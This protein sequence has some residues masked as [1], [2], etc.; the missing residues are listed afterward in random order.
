MISIT[1]R[2]LL[3]VATLTNAR[4]SAS[5]NFYVHGSDLESYKL[6]FFRFGAKLWNE[7]T[8]HIRHLSKNK[9]KKTLRKLLFD[10]L[11]SEYDYINTPTLIKKVKL[12]KNVEK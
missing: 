6:S 7:I 2:Y 3:A 10:I 8:C 12:G 1:M 9:F 5:G 11:N 4:A